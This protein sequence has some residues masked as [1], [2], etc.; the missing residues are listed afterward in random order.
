MGKSR[1]RY[2]LERHA[3]FAKNLKKCRR[4]SGLSMAEAS[5][6]LA[7]CGLKYSRDTIKRWEKCRATRLSEPAASDLGLIASCYGCSVTDFFLGL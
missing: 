1:R 3:R 7:A 5:Q 6:A 2:N 4:C